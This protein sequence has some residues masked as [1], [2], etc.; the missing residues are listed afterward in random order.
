[1]TFRAE[2]PIALTVLELRHNR[3]SE[4]EH[5]YKVLNVARLRD[6]VSSGDEGSPGYSITSTGDRKEVSFQRFTSIV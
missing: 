6:E 2:L 1:M 5:S 4:L 3:V